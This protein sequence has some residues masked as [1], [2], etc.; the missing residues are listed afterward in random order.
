MQLEATHVF[1]FSNTSKQDDVADNFL[2]IFALQALTAKHRVQVLTTQ[3][4]IDYWER[5]LPDNPH[6][7][8]AMPTSPHIRRERMP[9]K[10]AIL[11][12]WALPR[13]FLSIIRTKAYR[14]CVN[15]S[16]PT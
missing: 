8:V 1:A 6:I 13:G 12:D 2:E 5:R 16:Y 4:R 15:I 3:D 7:T 11:A 14:E 10:T 9:E